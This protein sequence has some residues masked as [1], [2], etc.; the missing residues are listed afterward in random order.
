M[1]QSSCRSVGIEFV[2]EVGDWFETVALEELPGHGDELLA[3]LGRVEDVDVEETAVVDVGE[4]EAEESEPAIVV[5]E[6]RAPARLLGAAVE[7]AGQV[8]T[9]EQRGDEEECLRQTQV[10]G[11]DGA[12]S[13]EHG[14]G[15]GREGGGISGVGGRR[16]R[17]GC[18]GRGDGSGLGAVERDEGGSALESDGRILGAATKANGGNHGEE[19]PIVVEFVDDEKVGEDDDGGGEDHDGQR[20]DEQQ[21]LVRLLVFLQDVAVILFLDL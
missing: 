18:S 5:A 20:L 3:H 14:H 4:K 12:S 6:R 1:R 13:V 15:V 8:E 21:D 9:D 19:S 17:H 16:G 11:S 10:G 7:V 2:A